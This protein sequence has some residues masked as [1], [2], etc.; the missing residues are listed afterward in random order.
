[1]SLVH[2]EAPG[3]LVLEIRSPKY[4]L[5]SISRWILLLFLLPLQV[6]CTA[7]SAAPIAFSPAEQAWLQQHP[8]INIGVD[9]NWP[10]ID[11]QD[12]Q[13]NAQGITIDY[14]HLIE[15]R[16]GIDIQIQSEPSWNEMMVRAKKGELDGV[17]TISKTPERE[18]LWNF[19]DPYMTSSYV[20]VTRRGVRNVNE[21]NDL[22]G[23]TVAM[24]KGYKLH[25]LLVKEFP[26][27]QLLIVDDSLQA[28]KAVSREQADA[29]V[30]VQHVALWLI[31]KHGLENIKV[32]ADSGF[33]SPELHVA[34][35]PDWPEF[36]SIVNRVFASV[37]YGEHRE[38][39]KRWVGR[40][41]DLEQ[42]E[43][44]LNTQEKVWLEQHPRI[45]V[46]I[47]NNWAPMDFVDKSGK[48]S[49]IGVDYIRALNKRLG[50]KLVVVPGDWS[51]I[52]EQV[53]N[54]QLDALMDITPKE[55]RKP[56]FNFTKPY[57]QIPHVII[58]SSEG[59]YYRHFED[60]AGKTVAIEKG[61]F[62]IKFLQ[63]NYPKVLIKEYDST[64]DAI[65]A[66]AKGESDA[67]VGNRAVALHVIETGLL[68]NL[69]VQGKIDATASI[70]SIGVRKDWPELALILD[71]A[72]ADITREEEIAILQ[73][74]GGIGKKEIPL[75]SKERAWLKKHPQLRLGV[76]AA[77]A[78]IEFIDKKGQ[79]RGMAADYMHA[80]AKQLNIE[81]VPLKEIAW[82]EVMEK[83]RRGE[84]DILPALTPSVEREKILNFTNSYLKYSLVIFTRTDGQYLSGL[85]DLKGKSVLVEKGYVTQEY[86]LRNHPEIKPI[87]VA[88]TAQAVEMLSHGKADAYFGNQISAGHV[89]SELGLTNIKVAAQTPYFNMLAVGVRKDWPELVPILQKALDSINEGEKSA[90]RNKWISIRFEKQIDYSLLWKVI[91]GALLVIFLVLIWV[92]QT[93]RQNRALNEGRQK[94]K[95]TLISANLG[96][97]D[98]YVDRAGSVASCS[99]NFAL[100]HNYPPGKHQF[101][102]KEYIS[103]IHPD[104]SKKVLNS[105]MHFVKGAS[106]ELSEEYLT[107]AGRWIHVEGKILEDNAA[108]VI[109]ISQDITER[110]RAEKALKEAEERSRLLL[111]SVGEGIFGVGLDGLFSFINPAGAFMLGYSPEEMM[112]QPVHALIHHTRA[113]GTDYLLDDCLM[114]HSYTKGVKRTRDDEVLWRKDG[115]CFPVLYNSVPVRDTEGELSGA[116]VVFHDITESKKAEQAII[117]ERERLQTILDTSPVGVSITSD[118]AIQFANPRFTELFGLHCGDSMSSSYVDPDDQGKM[119]AI[120]D[121]DGVLRDYELQSY[122][123]NR[124]IRDVMVSVQCIE[125]H[126]KESYLG[127]QVDISDLKRVQNELAS[128][129]VVAEEATKAKGDFLANMSHEIRTPMNAIIGLGHLA[130]MTE[131][132][133][134]Q[135]DYLTKI[136]SSSKALL[137]IINDIL[138]FSK[139]EAGKLDMEAIDFDL[140]EV[141]DNLTSMVALK[142][143]D[144]GLEFLIASQPDLPTNLVGDPLRLGQVL[145]NLVN[146][147]VKFTDEG[148]ITV[149]ISVQEQGEKEATLRFEVR[150]TGVGMTK[151]QRGKL[152]KAF[153]Q[154]DASTTR[155]YGGTGLGLTISKRLT[156]MMGGEIGVDSTVGEGS[157][158]HFTARFGIASHEIVKKRQ[159]VPNDLQGLRVLIVDDNATSREILANFM[160]SFGFDY[161]EAASGKEAIT[162]L[163]MAPEDH[164]YGLVLMDWKMPGMDGIQASKRIKQHKGLKT[165][166]SIIM[167]SSYG[168]EELMKKADEVGLDGYLVKP[169][170]QSMLFDTI[171]Y[172]FGKNT[173][174]R[175]DTHSTSIS[176]SEKL[177]GAHLLLVEDNEINQQ[178]ARE[179][180]GKAGITVSIANNGK[181]AIEAIER[182]YFDGV[183]M[184]LQMPVMGGIEATE[185]IRKDDRFQT[186][187]II[188][189]TANAM[190]G[191]RE[192]CIDAGMNDHIAKPIDITELFETLGRWVTP[193][194]PAAF[195]EAET[196]SEDVSP[197]VIEIPAMDGIDIEGGIRRVGG[198]RKL[199]RNILMKFRSSQANAVTEVKAAVADDD[200]ESAT[201]A[202]HTVKGVA[203]NIGADDLQAAA[204]ALE[205]AL[206]DGETEH[207]EALCDA[208]QFE[209]SRVLASTA[210]L[211]IDEEEEEQ[212]EARAVD[213]AV[214][215]PLLA[216]LTTLLEDDDT[217]AERCLDALE[218]ALKGTG[219]CKSELNGI[220]DSIGQYDF[221]EA[222]ELMKRMESQM[223]ERADA[224]HKRSV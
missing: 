70:N 79:Y 8:V 65:E 164:V 30:G 196:S 107:R 50:D 40:A 34:V 204:R 45:Q 185:K 148:D 25:E 97:W 42:K 155:K 119:R 149:A 219:L 68:K 135:R 172:A 141:L 190:T 147:A 180:L 31:E 178:V 177:R 127:W 139:I 165:I 131:M 90:I 99:D 133:A 17:A 49:G 175:K 12:S 128:A 61:F 20:I 115:S 198:N 94:L 214:V 71:R 129:K 168:R 53:K 86:L 150:D 209:L 218:V 5:T 158:F 124:E 52:Y 33:N 92:A 216:E 203:G 143:A 144:K 170:N 224:D 84:V 2:E 116:V 89:I 10:P 28:L 137:G 66:V 117:T 76:D 56:Y 126:G 184:D 51:D 105:F 221:E 211:E 16:T 36:K 160:D 41:H 6:V 181:E 82:N 192:K 24:E 112:G 80:V 72:L 120:M 212:G 85:D 206:E 27:I 103:S 15:Q 200:M 38:I 59:P 132:T 183:L 9:G 173:E 130:M 98:M 201:R 60:I 114:Y 32:T 169:V 104:Y 69:Q 106:T 108:R 205:S 123:P 174:D 3:E 93:K 215:D 96:S 199:Y 110:K 23:M 121:Q 81:F 22:I 153:S 223:I 140:N 83:T 54:G 194:N 197:D 37:T 47:N 122:G 18:K 142:A 58:A 159:V 100:H 136:N 118:G 182:E 74:W 217:D 14:L 57:A 156:E 64:T 63:Q 125:Y 46:A 75:T 191:D 4:A 207:L 157:T 161:G 210:C 166:P 162:E 11:F 43:F 167:V 102:S 7:A 67:Y 220:R 87:A 134:K 48:P 95:L 208:V 113:D 1:M 188:A 35:R 73:K 101:T 19:S 202:A 187:P 189:M 88:T 179:L 171:M 213:R 195:V 44:Q 152:F 145:I 186:L 26:G 138:D 111:E 21:I 55:E 91:I 78:P 77:W 151:K 146:N 176:I 109:G 39:L 163:E 13:G 222:L 62:I 29:Y 193:S 154:A